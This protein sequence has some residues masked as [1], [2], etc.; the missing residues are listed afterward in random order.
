VNLL[1]LLLGG[2]A[3][4]PV[5][6]TRF[7]EAIYSRLRQFVYQ[8]L[9]GR[10]DLVDDAAQEIAYQI[11]CSITARQVEYASSDRLGFA[12]NDH[13]IQWVYCIA[14]RTLSRY[15]A[16]LGRLL[17]SLD[18]TDSILQRLVAPD[19]AD[20]QEDIQCLHEC[21]DELSEAD[22]ILLT[23]RHLDGYD[24]DEIGEFLECSADAVRHRLIQARRRLMAV[25]TA[26]HPETAARW[27]GYE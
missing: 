5:D 11:L 9:R 10:L 23:Q 25:V 6:H 4:D 26:R 14:R 16:Q 18:P 13:L 1:D 21:L 24:S 17:G 2:C 19:S 27:Q 22:R 8:R 15:Q 7:L 12:G 20:V 3:C